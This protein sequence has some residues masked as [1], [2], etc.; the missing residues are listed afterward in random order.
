MKIRQHFQGRWTLLATTFVMGAALVITSWSN[1]R[2]VQE[3]RETL[4]G[5]EAEALLRSALDLLR[6]SAGPPS[7][8]L[9]ETFLERNEGRGLTYLGILRPNDRVVAEAGTRMAVDFSRS[10][11]KV[12]RLRAPEDGRVVLR[13]IAPVDGGPPRRNRFPARQESSPPQPPRRYSAPGPEIDDRPTTPSSSFSGPPPRGRR[14]RSPRLVLEFVPV[15]TAG[16]VARAQRALASSWLAAIALMAAALVF[17]RLSLRREA[18]ERRRQHEKRL[19]TLGEMSAVL[20]HEIRNPLA[21]LKGHAQLLAERL[22]AGSRE[23]AKADR[24]VLEATRLESLST[25]LLAFSKSGP[26]ERRPV[27]PAALLREVAGGLDGERIAIDAERSPAAW[28][29]D[30]VRWRQVVTNLL[31]NALQ[32]ADD[33]PVEATAEVAD[34]HLRLAVRDHGPGLPAGQEERIFEPFFTTRAS[35]T[36]LGLAVTRRIVE[37]HGGTLRAHNH[38]EGGAVFE[39]LLP[40]EPPSKGKPWATS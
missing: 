6:S 19:S 20:A 7:S 10:A 13:V 15:V 26:L 32:T 21:S 38:G 35:G 30:P 36:G 33:A 5:G 37:L 29:L 2:S 27:D 4:D 9:L 39:A 1:L 22:A 8:T 23:R 17:W 31:R 28:P 25:N 14:E 16:L 3:A 24:V 40:A 12:S 18:E 34:G 11:R